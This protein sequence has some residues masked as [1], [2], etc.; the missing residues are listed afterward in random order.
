[1]SI[2]RRHARVPSSVRTSA[3]FSKSC[4]SSIVPMQRKDAIFRIRVLSA[5]ESAKYVSLNS[6]AECSSSK[7]RLRVGVGDGDAIF[8][9]AKR[10]LLS[11]P[12]PYILQTGEFRQSPPKK[13]RSAMLS[14]FPSLKCIRPRGAISLCGRQQHLNIRDEHAEAHFYGYGGPDRSVRG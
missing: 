2:P 13:K 9:G 3:S 6:S 5:T 4:C 7:R 10:S 1:M 11:H 8:G 14:D 12:T